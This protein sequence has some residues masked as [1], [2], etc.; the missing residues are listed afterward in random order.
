MSGD[1]TPL[2]TISATRWPAATAR[3]L[4]RMQR[5]VWRKEITAMMPKI[6]LNRGS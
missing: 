6:H 2:Y 5:F 1:Y 4:S 3:F